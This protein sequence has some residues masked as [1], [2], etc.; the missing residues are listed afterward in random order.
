MNSSHR[1]AILST[2]ACIERLLARLEHLSTDS[3]CP[4]AKTVSDLTS[5]DRHAVA[6]FRCLRRVLRRDSSD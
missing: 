1:Q 3:T 5:A 2:F 6:D 4:I